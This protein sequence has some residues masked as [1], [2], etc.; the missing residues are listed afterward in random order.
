MITTGISSFFRQLNQHKIPLGII[1]LIWLIFWWQV[2]SGAQ[3]FYIRDLTFYALPYKTF[4]MS[5]FLA[6]KLPFWTPMISAGMPFIAEP[7][8]QVFYPA[9][10]IFFITPS[11]VHG[12]SWFILLHLLGAPIAMYTLSRV[13]RLQ[14]VPALFSALIYGYGGYVISISDNLNYLPSVVWA[15]LMLAAFI[16]G[17]K[18][19][20]FKSSLP[21]LALSA[22][23]TTLMILAGDVFTPMMLGFSCIILCLFYPSKKLNLKHTILFLFGSFLLGGLLAGIQILPTL[24]LMKWSVRQDALSYTETTL[25]SFPPQRLIEFIVPFFYGSKYNTFNYQGPHFLG[26]FL[27]PQFREPWV[28]SIYIGIITCFFSGLACVFRSKKSLPWMLIIIISL[29]ISMGSY[30]S[31]YPLLVKVLPVISIHRYLEKGLFITHIGIAVLSGLGVSYAY[32]H[33]TEATKKIQYIL[34][35]PRTLIGFGLLI[36]LLCVANQPNLL[37]YPYGPTYQSMQDFREY[38]LFYN[39][40]QYSFVVLLAGW[41]GLAIAENK[42]IY[43]ASTLIKKS[44]TTGL[45]LLG[46]TILLINLPAMMWIW[47]H[48]M[49]ESADW[50]KHFYMRGFHV[51]GL[52]MHWII[53]STL[54]L[55]LFWTAA[56]HQRQWILLLLVLGVINMIAI[57]AN[58]VPT[59]ATELLLPKTPQAASAIKQDTPEQFVRILYDDG[60]QTQENKNLPSLLKKINQYNSRPV[61]ESFYEYWIYRVLFSKERLLFN[62]GILY[63]LPYQNGRFSPLQPKNHKQ[64]DTA[65]KEYNPLLWLKLSGVTHIATKANLSLTS[66]AKFENNLSRIHH[67]PE[68]DL[69]ILALKNPIKRISVIDKY[70]LNPD[71]INTFK[72]T[73]ADYPED[74]PET[75]VELHT[76]KDTLNMMFNQFTADTQ[77][78]SNISA[79]NIHIIQ[80]EAGSLEFQVNNKKDKAVILINESFFPGWHALDINNGKELPILMANQRMMAIPIKAGHYHIK[81]TYKSRFFMAGLLVTVLGIFL[82]LFLLFK[83]I[84][85]HHSCRKGVS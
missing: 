65:L 21:P 26:M 4:M 67:A 59:G 52:M 51:S 35:K 15:P 43:N 58:H 19:S 7:S 62:S 25:W 78:K 54:I 46:A 80:D 13:L 8:H 55:T 10:L 14:Q 38:L 31:F 82:S 30:L 27:Y 34:L 83:P 79:E 63:Q 23:C 45:C 53:F 44:L 72:V 32:H 12:I 1:A 42:N 76:T 37:K 18:Q 69:S 64:M 75:L 73:E 24:E 6:G 41:I 50:G 56:K 40:I 29:L 28:D 47:S 33:I 11:V 57:H 20:T 22:I 36:I 85:T 3:Q 70:I 61:Q 74:K 48:T 2:I 68:H 71:P 81:L 16:H 39:L 84:Q 5:Q 49:E 66:W 9:N 60:V 77:L 17:L